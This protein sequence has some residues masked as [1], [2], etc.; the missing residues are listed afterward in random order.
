MHGPELNRFYERVDDRS[1]KGHA[2]L[3]QIGAKTFGIGEVVAMPAG[4]VHAV[5]NESDA[6]SV[7]LHIYGKHI[8][9]TQRSQ[10][11][12]DERTETPFVVKVN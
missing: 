10:Y 12:P 1:R 2:E 9:F 3:K 11:D 6:V 8:N 5:W 4:A 7:S